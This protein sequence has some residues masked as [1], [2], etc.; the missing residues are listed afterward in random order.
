MVR[1]W[2]IKIWKYKFTVAFDKQDNFGDLVA[3]IDIKERGTSVSLHNVINPKAELLV[4]SHSEQF[5]LDWIKINELT[6]DK[7][8]ELRNRAMFNI[9]N[10]VKYPVAN[11]VSTIGL[12]K[13]VNNDYR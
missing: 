5:A 13:S 7:Y 6:E 8:L 3:T 10:G 4:Y 12:N 2:H 11:A 1:V 9:E